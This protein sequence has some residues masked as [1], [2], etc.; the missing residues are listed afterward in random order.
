MNQAL[1]TVFIF[2]VLFA[3]SASP[4]ATLVAELSQEDRAVQPAKGR[5]ARMGWRHRVLD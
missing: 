4:Q 5:R 1:P 2:G 3:I